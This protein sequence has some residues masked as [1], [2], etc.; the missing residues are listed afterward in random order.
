MVLAPWAHTLCTSKTV[1]V[2][3]LRHNLSRFL[4]RMAS[5]EKLLPKWARRPPRERRWIDCERSDSGPLH[6]DAITAAFRRLAEKAKLPAGTRLHDFRHAL[7]V[8]LMLEHVPLKGDS[9]TLGHTSESFTAGRAS[10]SWTNYRSKWWT[11]QSDG[12]A[13]HRGRERKRLSVAFAKCLQQSH[14]SSVPSREQPRKCWVKWSL[15][16][17]ACHMEPVSHGAWEET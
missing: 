12:W 9:A 5:G 14:P 10:T 1:G 4:Q 17:G 6:P 11:P 3:E 2:A 8:T 7:A 16:H 13:G 15:S